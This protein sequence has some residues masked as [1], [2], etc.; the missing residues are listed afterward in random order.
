M[1]SVV[2]I[3]V[4]MLSVIMLSVAILSVAILSVAILS[5][6]MLSVITLSFVKLCNKTGCLLLT[7]V[8]LS[9][10]TPSVVAPSLSLPP[11][12]SFSFVPC[13]IQLLKRPR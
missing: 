9:A 8:Q 13:V 5:V 12:L 10:D 2:L 3:S 1:L 6:A 7:F 11:S 4:I